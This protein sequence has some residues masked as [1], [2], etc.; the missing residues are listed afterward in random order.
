MFSDALLRALRKGHPFLGSRL[1]LSELGDLIKLNLREMYPN[2]WV[3]PEVHSPDQREGD[4]ASIG[5]FPNAAY[6]PEKARTAQDRVVGERAS[7]GDER[8]QETETSQWSRDPKRDN[9]GSERDAQKTI[10]VT[11]KGKQILPLDIS[12]ETVGGVATSM[13][14]RDTPIPT[15]KTEIF[16]TAADG[17]SSVEI[18][19]LFG[20]R[21]MA[22]D[23][24]TL[25][26][27]HLLGIPSAPRGV[28][29]IE[30]TF[31]IDTNGILNVTAKDRA[32][33]NDRKM[34]VTSSSG[35]SKEEVDLMVSEAEAHVVEDKAKR[36]E[37][38]SRNQLDN[39]VY[40]VEEMLKEHGKKISFQEKSTLESAL[41]DAKKALESGDTATI[42]L[43]S[44]TLTQASYKLAEVLYRNT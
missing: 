10:Y 6:S 12:I 27:F 31:E 17:Q 5:V 28:P 9:Q 30:V 20:N 42:N 34:I 38:E 16:S 13:L 44:Q 3:R 37:I 1:S 26:K 15:R 23:N 25:G 40:K 8:R 4:I 21:P 18:H 35:L 39:M 33:G 11:Q 29:Q 19:L 32:T 2:T 43:T 22:R 7:E 41:V 14:N 24:R 36:D